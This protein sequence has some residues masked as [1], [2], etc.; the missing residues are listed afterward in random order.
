MEF[1]TLNRKFWSCHLWGRVY[2]AAGSGNI[3]DEVIMKYIE[4]QGHEPPEGDFK[5]DGDDL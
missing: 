1:K 4:R 2:F 3:T 5:I